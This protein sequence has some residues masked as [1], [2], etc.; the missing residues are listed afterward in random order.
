[1]SK[2]K[3]KTQKIIRIGNS[4]GVTLDYEFLTKNDLKVG[5]T[6]QSHYGSDEASITF[7]RPPTV[8]KQKPK[9]SKDEKKAILESKVDQ[10]FRNWVEKS[11]KEDEESLT[12][13]ANL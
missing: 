5:D 12:K 10:E 11:L 9:L 4:V 3:T 7:L 8:Q 13:L 1:M 6:I 2:N